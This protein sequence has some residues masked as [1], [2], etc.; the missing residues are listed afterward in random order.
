MDMH[1]EGRTLKNQGCSISVFS[2]GSFGLGGSLSLC[3]SVDRS[4]SI[5]EESKS[6]RFH[7]VRRRGMCLFTEVVP[8]TGANDGFHDK[9][10]L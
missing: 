8:G 6:G 2:V 10:E 1:G 3:L 7:A 5:D 4:A 9:S